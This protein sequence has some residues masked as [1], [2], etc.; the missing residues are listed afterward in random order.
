MSEGPPGGSGL[1]ARTSQR[2][3]SGQDAL[4]EVQNGL[5]APFGR[6]G[7]L[8]QPYWRSGRGREFLSK[9]GTGQKD[10]P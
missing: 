9:A 1:V 7:W 2:F 3:G 4:P 10:L 5:R 6:T 8:L